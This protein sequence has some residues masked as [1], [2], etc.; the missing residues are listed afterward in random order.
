MNDGKKRGEEII[1]VKGWRGLW[2]RDKNEEYKSQIKRLLDFILITF[3]DAG[4][5]EGEDVVDATIRII[6]QFI[7]YRKEIRR[8]K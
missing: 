8:N 4:P 5:V 6:R 3:P 7:K 2:V 1:H